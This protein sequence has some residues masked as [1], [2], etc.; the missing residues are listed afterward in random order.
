MKQI[1]SVLLAIVM[2]V[3]LL[4]LTALAVEYVAPEVMETSTVVQTSSTQKTVL[5]D[6]MTDVILEVDSGAGWEQ[7]GPYN[8]YA[9]LS[10]IPVGTQIRGVV[11][12]GA[13]R[14]FSQTVT[15]SDE[16]SNVVLPVREVEVTGIEIPGL[17]IVVRHANNSG[18]GTSMIL[19]DTGPNNQSN[20]LRFYTW[21]IDGDNQ[22]F[23]VELAGSNFGAPRFW[24]Q[25]FEIDLSDH[26]YEVSIPDG[27]TGVSVRNAGG[28]VVNGI[29]NQDSGSFWLINSG[30]SGAFTFTFEGVEYRLSDAYFDG[31][32]PFD[33]VVI[34]RFPGASGITEI[35]TQMVGHGWTNRT[36]LD[37]SDNFAFLNTKWVTPQNTDLLFIQLFAP[38][39]SFSMHHPTG[40]APAFTVI[41]IPVTTITVINDPGCDVHVSSQQTGAPGQGVPGRTGIWITG[42]GTEVVLWVFD[43]GYHWVRAG[44][45]VNN[46]PFVTLDGLLPGARVYISEFFACEVC[47]ECRYCDEHCPQSTEPCDVCDEYPCECPLPPLSIVFDNSSLV[48]L[49]DGSGTIDAN[50]IGIGNLYPLE[51]YRLEITRTFI[52]PPTAREVVDVNA[53][54]TI[55]FCP[56]V[57]RIALRIVSYQ[58]TEMVYAFA[59]WARPAP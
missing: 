30:N 29:N 3:G 45:P 49:P 51:N 19:Y 8:N 31:T 36:G 38:G 54:Q 52:D 16:F 5:F 43:Y 26:F 32:N 7:R 27:V 2:L 47:E 53:T 20:D 23:G 42:E 50:V 25:G 15:T 22:W 44:A 35:R 58:N 4:T 9:V 13:V 14:V 48:V 59:T 55:E 33:H 40:G 24:H 10:D 46:H 57:T 56:N 37:A 41:D 21:D 39:L 17:R 34:L 18:H 12:P 28:G 1:I 6:G 11:T